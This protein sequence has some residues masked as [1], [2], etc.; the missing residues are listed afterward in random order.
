MTI[1]LDGALVWRPH[2]KLDQQN[3]LVQCEPGPG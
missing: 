3:T 2:Q 1:S